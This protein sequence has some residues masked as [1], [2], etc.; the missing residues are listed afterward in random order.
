[1]GVL[2]DTKFPILELP[3]QYEK[4]LRIMMGYTFKNVNGHIEVY[5]SCGVFQFSADTEQEAVAD[6]REMLMD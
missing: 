6:L 4:E 3:K 1:M 5:D 2:L